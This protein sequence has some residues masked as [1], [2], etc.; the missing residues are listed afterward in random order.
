MHA[1]R[2]LDLSGFY[3]L[4]GRFQPISLPKPKTTLTSSLSLT[5]A[6]LGALGLNIEWKQ[7]WPGS[8][9]LLMSIK[10]SCIIISHCDID[11]T[12]IYGAKFC[13]LSAHESIIA[14]E[15]FHVSFLIPTYLIY[16]S[17]RPLGCLV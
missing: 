3:R 14:P 6:S 7:R 13:L 10:P 16:C 15:G 1:L 5:D 12:V 11:L 17:T 2:W 9:T 4:A 8:R